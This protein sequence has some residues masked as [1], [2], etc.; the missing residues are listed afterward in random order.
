VTERPPPPPTIF[1]RRDI[2]VAATAWGFSAA[3][4][5]GEAALSRFG[6]RFRRGSE[7]AL[8]GAVVSFGR[9]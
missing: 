2:L 7:E 4:K 6:D 1:L 5:G 9:R 8:D 3:E